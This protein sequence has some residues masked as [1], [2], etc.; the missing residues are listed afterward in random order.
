MY[1]DKKRIVLYLSYLILI[2]VSNVSRA[3][4]DELLGKKKKVRCGMALWGK[5]IEFV[6]ETL[7]ELLTLDKGRNIIFY[8][9][10]WAK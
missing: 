2:K 8:K 7:G 4:A 10:I 5:T 9:N 6:V 1:L 3:G